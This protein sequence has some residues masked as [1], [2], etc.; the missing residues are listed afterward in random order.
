MQINDKSLHGA[1]IANGRRADFIRRLQALAEEFGHRE[2]VEVDSVYA[3]DPEWVES[4]RDL[5]PC[6]ENIRIEEELKLQ[7]VSVS[8]AN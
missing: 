5:I 8:V 1:A 2:A 3:I 4:R 6:D 7:R